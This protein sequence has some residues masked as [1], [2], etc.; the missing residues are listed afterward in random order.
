V[1]Q[2]YT[3]MKNLIAQDSGRAI[4]FIDRQVKDYQSLMVGVKPGTEVVVLDGQT[5][6]NLIEIIPHWPICDPLTLGIAWV[7]KTELE[8]GGL[9]GTLYVDALKNALSL[10][11]LHRCVQKP[12]MRDC[13]GC[14]DFG[15]LQIV[16]NYR[17]DY[18][19][20]DLHLAEIAKLV[21]MSPD[22]FCRLFKQ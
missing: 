7:L 13:E 21:Q 20:R 18:L 22:Y 19:S 15:K 10:H 16:I 2:F 9:N 11:L 6:S 4:A 14:L 12:N 3:Y 8:S 5:N 17:N 1:S